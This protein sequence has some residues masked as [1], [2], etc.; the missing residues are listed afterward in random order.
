MPPGRTCDPEQDF[1]RFSVNKI[2]FIQQNWSFLHFSL[3]PRTSQASNVLKLF[4]IRRIFDNT[5][6]Q[7]GGQMDSFW[8]ETSD[9][10]IAS[11]MESQKMFLSLQLKF[12]VK[13]IPVLVGW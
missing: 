5:N 8:Q 12:S 4:Y 3:D 6:V 1:A 9:K 13:D 11:E 7:G 10:Q 2:P